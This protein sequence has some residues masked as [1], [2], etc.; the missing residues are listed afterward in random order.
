MLDVMVIVIEEEDNGV[1]NNSTF[2]AWSQSLAF[3]FTLKERKTESC[4]TRFVAVGQVLS[5]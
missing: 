1:V 5:E 2:P 4:V 3:Q